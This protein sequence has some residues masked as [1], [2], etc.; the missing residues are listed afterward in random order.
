MFSVRFV[1]VPSNLLHLLPSSLTLWPELGNGGVGGRLE[2]WGWGGRGLAG[3]Y[4]ADWRAP[5]SPNPNRP[6]PPPHTLHLHPSPPLCPQHPCPF[7]LVHCRQISRC[8]ANATVR[9]NSS[10]DS[11]WANGHVGRGH[12]F[13]NHSGDTR[14]K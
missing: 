4:E 10:T 14:L 6:P 1:L 12:I 5:C 13:T 7:A 2:R 11:P 8:A 3:I 9:C